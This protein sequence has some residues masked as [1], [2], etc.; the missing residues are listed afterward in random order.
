MSNTLDHLTE[1]EARALKDELTSAIQE[2][3]DQIGAF[4][5]RDDYDQW[6]ARALHA[7][8]LKERQLR[9]VKTHLHNLAQ[10]GHSDYEL[11]KEAH[12]ILESLDPDHCLITESEQA[13]IG[14]LKERVYGGANAAP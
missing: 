7:K 3:Q 14:R 11:L 10:Q 4:V 2:I 12:G 9:A 13:F 5:H 8:R 1:S 6:K